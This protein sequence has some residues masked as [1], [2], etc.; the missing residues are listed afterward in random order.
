MSTYICICFYT[1]VTLIHDVCM[2]VFTYIY[3]YIYI[4]IYMCVSTYTST[5]TCYMY[6]Y[7]YLYMYIYI[8]IYRAREKER[9]SCLLMVPTK[10]FC[11]DE[12]EVQMIVVWSLTQGC[13]FVS[14]VCT[15][16]VCGNT[17]GIVMHAL[18]TFHL[19]FRGERFDWACVV[20]CPGST[21]M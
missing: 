3:I 17:T 21:S 6:I 14:S 4:Y 7:I 16:S 5:Y 1:C 15:E 13:L 20:H 2:Y 10:D 11:L 8:Y 18:C 9:Q 12:W 19:T